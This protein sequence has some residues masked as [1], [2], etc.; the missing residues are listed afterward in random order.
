LIRV[1]F[2]LLLLISLLGLP[3]GDSYGET[4]SAH[5]M[6]LISPLDKDKEDIQFQGG[7]WGIFSKTPSLGRHSSKAIAVD[8]KIN[9]LIATLT[10]LCETQSGVPL[11]ELATY[12]SRKLTELGKSEF[13]SLHITLG[14]PEKDIE[15][16]LDYTKIALANRNRVLELGQIKK[17]IQGSGVLIEKYRALFS[18]FQN[19]NQTKPLLS[20]TIS[21]GKN[22]DDIF[23]NDPYLALAIFEESQVPFWDVDENYGGS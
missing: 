13:K 8:S 15:V 3:A 19:N 1:F 18:D 17:S 23:V 11:N 22:I 2:N 14:K 21:L 9:K 10:Y 6:S 16:W 5:C 7:I 12:V 20:R 4:D